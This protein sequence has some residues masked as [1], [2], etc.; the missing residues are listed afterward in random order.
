VRVTISCG[1]AEF[2]PGDTLEA[3]FERADRAMYL[4]KANGRNRVR[5][6][7]VEGAGAAP[8]QP[9]SNGVSPSVLPLAEG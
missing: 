2:R 3:V 7:T 8:Q 1:V 9:A 6:E 4:A 5:L